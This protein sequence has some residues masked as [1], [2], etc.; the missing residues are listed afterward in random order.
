MTRLPYQ[1]NLNNTK[2]DSLGSFTALFSSSNAI[3]SGPLFYMKSP[4]HH[5]IFFVGWSST[6]PS[7]LS[8]Q[9]LSHELKLEETKGEH[10][11]SSQFILDP[12]VRNSIF[13]PDLAFL[14]LLHGGSKIKYRRIKA[15]SYLLYHSNGGH[16]YHLYIIMNPT[17]ITKGG[18]QQHKTN[19]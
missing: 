17:T 5:T 4:H 10:L 12:N 1:S 18:V 15:T 6:T 19:P 8:F 11:L 13:I 14:N 9:K 3:A 2:L 7:W 16:L